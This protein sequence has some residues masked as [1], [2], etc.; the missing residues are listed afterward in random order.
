MNL[1]AWS[2]RRG[3]VPRRVLVDVDCDVRPDRVLLGDDAKAKAAIAAVKVRQ[4]VTEG[5]AVH[6]DFM[7][8][9]PV[10]A[11]RTGGQNPHPDNTTASKKENSGTCL[12]KQPPC[13]PSVRLAQ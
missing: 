13:C 2:E 1:I 5:R 4:D 3:Q 12:K 8:L 6:L 10:G 11:K 7:L 9:P